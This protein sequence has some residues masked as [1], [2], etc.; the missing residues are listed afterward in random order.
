MKNILYS[1]M[2]TS[3]NF[4]HVFM[5]NHRPKPLR[6]CA[7]FKLQMQLNI[8]TQNKITYGIQVWYDGYIGLLY[9]V[10]VWYDNDGHCWMIMA[11]ILK[12]AI[13]KWACLL[14]WSLCILAVSAFS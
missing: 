2:Q 6:W 4:V 1:H 5:I 3:Y 13:I 14:E 12:S 11:A 8:Q 10:L 9:D 7:N